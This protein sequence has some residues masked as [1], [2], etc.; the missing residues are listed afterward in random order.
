MSTYYSAEEKLRT[1]AQANVTLQSFL[2]SGGIFRWFATQLQPGYASAGS[3]VRVTRPSAV[4]T[5]Q[6]Q[7]PLSL[8]QVRLQFDCIDQSQTT[9]RQLMLAVKDFLGTVDLMS[10]AQF[11]SPPTTPTQFPNYELSE[12]G[13]LVEYQ[14]SLQLWVWAMD[15]RIFNDT[16]ITS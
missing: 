5:Y 9:A 1:L 3:C 13:P 6:Q 8:D 4:Y 15:W 14:A 11:T 7:G 16:L 2:L 10:D 12:R